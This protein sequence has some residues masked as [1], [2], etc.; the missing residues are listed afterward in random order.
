M[1]CLAESPAPAV[2]VSSLQICVPERQETPS[3]ASISAR[4]SVAARARLSPCWHQLLSGHL[5]PAW[6]QLADRQLSVWIKK[7][8]SHTQ[9]HCRRQ[10][11]SPTTFPN[12][13]V[14]A[15]SLI[16]RPGLAS[17]YL[18]AAIKPAANVTWGDSY[19][20]FCF[21]I[22]LGV[23]HVLLFT[24]SFVLE[25]KAEHSPQEFLCAKTE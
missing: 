18:P 20:C 22:W 14:V 17:R 10:S 9:T 6:A 25:V 12:T 1:F 24:A 11:P 5:H 3:P 16:R 2:S 19:L 4:L 13:F 7:E 21:F 23:R 15:V 8:W